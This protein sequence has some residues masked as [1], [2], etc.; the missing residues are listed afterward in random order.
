MLWGRQG[1][2]SAFNVIVCQLEAFDLPPGSRLL[3]VHPADGHENSI[4]GNSEISHKMSIDYRKCLS[5][6]SWHNKMDKTYCKID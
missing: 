1:C 6:E 3:A 4:A 2:S 5:K